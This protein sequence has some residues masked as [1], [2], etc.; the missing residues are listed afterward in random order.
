MSL[1]EKDGNPHA[2]LYADNFT[3]SGETKTI[4]DDLALVFGFAEKSE[5]WIAN[6][7]WNLLWRDA[8]LLFQAP[9]PMS[10]YENT[11]VLEPNVQRFTVA[12]VVNAVVPQLYKGLFFEDPPMLLRPRE[13]TSQK[14]V[15]EKTTVI[16]YL[17]D[18][19]QFKREVKWGLESLAHLGTGIWKWGI[20]RVEKKIPRRISNQV[21]IDTGTGETEKVST[22]APP[23]IEV[24]VRYHNKPFFEFRRLGSIL[25]SA[26]LKVADIREA[27]EVADVQYMN[28]YEL[29]DLKDSSIG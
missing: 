11:Y 20:E 25:V 4:A 14:T 7:Q 29:K 28:F 15:D 22:D 6:K 3:P 18:A 24:D 12:K 2:V 8:D 26:D 5:A 10:V 27:Q 17:L 13:G 23:K 19:C 9:R 1:L 21:S 16:S